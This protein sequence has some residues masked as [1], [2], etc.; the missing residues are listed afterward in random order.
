MQTEKRS[1][2]IP[3]VSVQ[4]KVFR[5]V[6][7]REAF[8]P[9]SLHPPHAKLERDTMYYTHRRRRQAHLHSTERI[10]ASDSICTVG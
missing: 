5:L 9:L 8:K 6:C 1:T 3:T 10:C 2:A 4:L 7:N